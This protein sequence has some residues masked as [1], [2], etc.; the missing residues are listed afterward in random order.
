MSATLRV[1]TRGSPLAILQAELVGRLVSG[2]PSGAPNG[3]ARGIPSRNWELVVVKTRGDIETGK[4]LSA[5]G[6]EGIFVKEVQ[7][8]VIDGRADIAVHSAKDLPSVTPD[9]LVLACVPER[10]DPRDAFVGR[11]HE[12][13]VHDGDIHGT[14]EA[15]TPMS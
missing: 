1:A 3:A 4:S 15:T 9:G 11:R 2:T 13:A 6:G 14:S 5:V 10:A 12:G 7:Q 8:A